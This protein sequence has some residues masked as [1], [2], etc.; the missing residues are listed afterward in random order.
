MV[1]ATVVL[2]PIYLIVSELG[3]TNNPWGVILR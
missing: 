1:P 2:V 3:L